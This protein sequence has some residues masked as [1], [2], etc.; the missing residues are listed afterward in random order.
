MWAFKRTE[1]RWCCSR[2]II[3]YTH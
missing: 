1:V 3:C 2:F